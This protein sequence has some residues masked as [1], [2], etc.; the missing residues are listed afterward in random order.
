MFDVPLARIRVVVR[1]RRRFGSKTYAKLEPWPHPRARGRSAGAGAASIPKHSKRCA[2]RLA[3]RDARRLPGDGTLVAVECDA[4]YDVGAYADIGASRSEG[5]YTAT[6]P[7]RVSHV[8]LEARAV[9][10]NTSRG[11][12]RGF[13][14]PQLAWALESLFD[15]AADRLK[16]DPWTPAQNFLATEE[17]GPVTRRSTQARG[18]PGPR[19]EAM[20]GRR[21]P[22]RSRTR[23][24]GDAQ[25][26]VAP[27]VSEAIVRLHA[28]GSVT[29]LAS[30]VRWGRDAHRARAD[31][32]RGAERRARS[33]TVVQPDTAVTPYDQTTS[34]S[35]STAMTGRRCK[36]PRGRP[37][38]ASGR[39]GA[40]SR[41]SHADL[42]LWTRGRGSVA[43]LTY[44]RR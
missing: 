3:R 4:D 21:R 28:D 10:T 33:V 20:A 12:F 38:A 39:R 37:R 34:S 6:G 7:Y 19:A 14:V 2:V 5:T 29:V 17:F 11:A 42:A 35:R 18:E 24:G 36:W 9:Y 8:R 44:A 30:A 43:A 1:T 25:G 22:R 26:L 32:G 31:R 16:R 13:G 41:S 23:R 27:S 15:V 40:E